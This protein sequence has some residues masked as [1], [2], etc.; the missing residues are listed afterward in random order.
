MSGLSRRRLD[1][2]RS[3]LHPRYVVWELTLRCDHA[4]THCGSRAGVAREIELTTEQALAVV[5]QLAAMGTREVVLIG[6]EAYLHEGF[7]D[8]VGALAA[9]D[10]STVMTTG[11]R[12]LD[13]AMAVRLRDA[14]MSRVSVSV[15][16]LEETHDRMRARR[17]SFRDALR[18]LQAIGDA[19]LGVQANTNFNRLNEGDL[20]PLADV[21]RDAGVK[22]WQVQLTSPLGRAADRPDMLLQPY[23]LL[24][25]LPRIAA[26]KAR[27]FRDG[28]L[29]MPGNN[30]GYFGPEEALLRSPFEGGADHFRGCQAGRFVMGIESDGAVKGCPSLQSASYVGGTLRERSMKEIWDES[31]ELAFARA[32]TPEQDLWGFCASCPYAATC[33]GGCS[34]T[35]HSFFGRPGNN[36]YCHFRAISHRRRGLRERLVA[37]DAASGRPFDHGLFEVVVEPWD[38]PLPVVDRRPEQLVRL[39]RRPRRPDPAELDPS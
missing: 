30:L 35:A 19:G 6:G 15:D 39:G 1:V 38:A 22:A 21:L 20:E 14:G 8:I 3:E 13:G 31:P 10:I 25:L 11:G 5:D 29:L 33:M 23:E 9:R 16:G 7:F 32:R 24:E 26:I 4:C 12:A 27:G 37:T 18:A 34:F 2:V 28:M 17:G 36:P